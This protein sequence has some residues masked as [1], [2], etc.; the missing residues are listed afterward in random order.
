MCMKTCS[1][2]QLPKPL[3]EFRVTKKGH[4]HSYC[5]ECQRLYDRE[6]YA[7]K[8][9]YRKQINQEWKDRQRSLVYALKANP[10]TD[11]GTVYHPA[12]M[13]FDHLPGSEKVKDVATLMRYASTERL[14]DEIA[15]C[16][17]VCANCHAVR[18]WE[19]AQAALAQSEEHFLGMEEV[20]GS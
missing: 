6:R 17:L 14:L 2:C 20:K 15:K 19:R 8:R 13:H 11:C 3:S 7:A 4:V 12:A 16:E 5:H 10:C 1:K 9:D 18:T